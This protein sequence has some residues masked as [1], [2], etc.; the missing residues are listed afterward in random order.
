[1]LVG[2]FFQSGLGDEARQ[3]DLG[4]AWRQLVRWLTADVPDRMEVRAEEAGEAIKLRVWARDE[5]FEP[6][7]HA[8]VTLAI[9]PTSGGAAPVLMPAEASASEAGLFEATYYPRV[10]GGYRVEAT[11]EGD[12]GRVAGVAQT[13]WTTNLATT[14]YRDLRPN[15]AAMEL[16]AK[17]T[18][19]RVLKPSEL[20]E[21]ASRLPSERAPVMETWTQP[22]WHTPWVMLA[23]LA[24]FIFEWTLRRRSGLA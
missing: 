16:L 15:L 18:G 5:R 11:V 17:Q 10:S 12:E 7:D 21:F 2:D 13:G 8:R 19:G 9:A 20:A 3:K 4:R 22:L 6:M 14:E 24:C 23:A 1:M